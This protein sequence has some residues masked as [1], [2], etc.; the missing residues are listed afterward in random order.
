MRT[1]SAESFGKSFARQGEA[2]V[3]FLT[4]STAQVTPH[5]QEPATF[6][7]RGPAAGGRL[8]VLSRRLFRVFFTT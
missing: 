5:Q 3:K 8:E 7:N 1:R 4:R 2:D 6:V